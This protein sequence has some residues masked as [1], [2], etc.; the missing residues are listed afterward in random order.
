M[1]PT[2][3]PC[4]CC[5]Y[6]KLTR[7][8]LEL[9]VANLKSFYRA[10]RGGLTVVQRCMHKVG[11][12][13]DAITTV[14][15]YCTRFNY[16]SKMDLGSLTINIIVK[17]LIIILFWWSTLRTFCTPP[18]SFWSPMPLP[19]CLVRL[20]LFSDRGFWNWDLAYKNWKI[21]LFFWMTVSTNRTNNFFIVRER[22][23]NNIWN[24]F[25]IFTIN[26]NIRNPTW[27]IFIIFWNPIIHMT[28]V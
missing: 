20:M 24:W 19:R 1:L 7:M 3:I 11:S 22:N 6:Y 21:F 18:V 8:L 23:C 27:E 17:T 13:H 14:K 2:P 16:I 28:K 5:C 10:S 15:V 25:G 4:S 9:T 26:T 12:A